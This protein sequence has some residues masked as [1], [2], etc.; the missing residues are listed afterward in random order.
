[1]FDG[2]VNGRQVIVPHEAVCNL[3]GS[4]D[5]VLLFDTY[6]RLLRLSG[7]YRFVRC[8][9]CGL[10]YVNP[11][12]TWDERAPHYGP[13]YRGYH[14][15]ETERSSIQ[16][17]AMEYGLYK[18]YRLVATCSRGGRLLDAGCGG[19]DFLSRMRREAGWQV[20]GLERVRQIALTAHR[21]H[22]LNVV[23]GDLIQA[24]FASGYFDVVTLWA[25]LEHL[26][27]PMQGLRE[28][29]RILRPG[30]ALVIR[31]VTLD[32]WGSRLFGPCWVGYDA[33]RV[34]FVFSRAT[35]Q[36]MLTEAGF[37]ATYMGCHFHDFFPFLWSWQNVSDARF[38]TRSRR[39]LA[40]KV[41]S[42]WP[43]RLVTLP[44][45]IVQTLLG[46]NSFVSVVA[47]KR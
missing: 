39:Q 40:V 36:C 21:F 14:R 7:S 10:V 17:R 8:R 16:R 13:S 19:G 43:I 1:V 41:A 9:V 3:C 46:R 33:P 18:R 29:A 37:E 11:Q 4:E 32:S 22:G 38:G 42:S 23:V 28:C 45:F 12:P 47:R 34:L 20:Y 27:D 2:W 31:T 44:F 35:L 25:A 26:S 30:G 5:A 6:D 24:G 15:L